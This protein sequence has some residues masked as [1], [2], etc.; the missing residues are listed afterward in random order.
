M[1]NL[2]YLYSVSNK[3]YFYSLLLILSKAQIFQYL[4]IPISYIFFINPIASHCLFYLIFHSTQPFQSPPA[5]HRSLIS[6]VLLISFAL[7]KQGTSLY[8]RVTSFVSREADRRKIKR[9]IDQKTH[10]W[11]IQGISIF[12]SLKQAFKYI[13]IH[14]LVIIGNIL[15]MQIHSI[16]MTSLTKQ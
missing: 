2:L 7:L 10:D 14:E 13:E 4:Q 1:N 16:F 12:R 6:R 5:L 15:L 11:P 9:R 3:G 8:I